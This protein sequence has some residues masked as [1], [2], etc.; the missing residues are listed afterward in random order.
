M[1][2]SPA[3][4]SILWHTSCRTTTLV[5]VW[6][7]HD[8]KELDV[9]HSWRTSTPSVMTNFCVTRIMSL[10]CVGSLMSVLRS[11]RK[12][13]ATQQRLVMLARENIIRLELSQLL[14]LSENDPHLGK[15]SATTWPEWAEWA[16][17]CRKW[18]GT[19]RR[20]NCS[21]S[22]ASLSRVSGFT[23]PR[24]NP[25]QRGSAWGRERERWRERVSSRKKRERRSKQT[26]QAVVV[27]YQLPLVFPFCHAFLE[28]LRKH[29]DKA[30]NR[31][32]Q[33]CRDERRTTGGKPV[34]VC[35]LAAR[36]C[37]LAQDWHICPWVTWA[38]IQKLEKHK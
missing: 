24:S 28:A 37:E 38:R 23:S 5:K 14:L 20:A 33:H 12:D 11:G 15:V 4:E 2:H 22:S 27:T 16:L 10:L 7:P 26:E 19:G 30:I 21:P 8:E 25:V 31:T 3:G 9:T 13:T 1:N 32:N 35:C 6:S 18:G 36:L 34:V 29:T 17:C